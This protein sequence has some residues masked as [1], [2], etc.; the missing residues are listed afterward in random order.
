MVYLFNA[1]RGKKKSESHKTDNY[2]ESNQM[3]IF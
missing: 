2:F 1:K 3:K